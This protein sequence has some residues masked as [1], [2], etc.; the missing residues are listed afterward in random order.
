MS[1]VLSFF[2]SLSRNITMNSFNIYVFLNY[3][4]IL[5]V[6]IAIIRFK[7]VLKTFY[8]FIFFIWLGS[9]NETVSL[10][11]IHKYKS[12]AIN[13]NIYVLAEYL[14]LLWQFYKWNVNYAQNCVFSAGIGILVWIADNLLVNAI[15][16][17][18]SIFRIFYS[19]I[20]VFFSIDMLNR[21]IV[22]EKNSSSKNAV[23]LV[24]IG[25]LIYYG[26]KA[27]LEVFNAF[28]LGFSDM[29]YKNIW[30]TLSVVNFIANIIYAIAILCIPRKQE[31]SLLY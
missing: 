27:L 1:S 7:S 28:N 9:A 5:A 16:S 15:D 31:F 3:S 29:F 14:L 21:V 23:F 12:N 18:N 11:L 17:N 19:F 22:N 24:C 30:I 10:L 26:F 25:L 4:I 2:I 20:I 8:P 6:I 13:S